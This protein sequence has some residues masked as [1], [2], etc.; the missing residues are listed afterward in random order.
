MRKIIILLGVL[1]LLIIAA[2]GIARY[3]YLPRAWPQTD[4]TLTLAGLQAPVEVFR[5]KW[6]I[7]NIYAQNE[8][9]LFFAQGYVHA[10][11]RLWQMDFN[12]RIGSGRLSELVGEATLDTDI[13]LRHLGMH[14]ASAKDWE[15]LSPEVR[16]ILTA[17]VDGVNTYIESHQGRLPLEYTI[18]G[19][20]PEPWKPLDSIVWAKVM[21]W[22]L[23][24]NWEAELLRARL[25]NQVGRQAVADLVPPYPQDAPV[26]VPPGV[27]N[28]AFLQDATLT[29]YRPIRQV[30]GISTGAWASNN[31]VVSGDKSTT[32]APLLANDP[33]LGL[34]IPSVWYANGLHAPDFDVVGVTFPGIPGIVIGHNRNI[35]WGVTNL[36]PDIQDL[37]IEKINPDNPNQYEFQGQ[38]EEMQVIQEVIRVKGRP[39]PEVV[40]V[41]ITRHG[42]IMNPAVESL[43]GALQPLAMR[44]TALDGTTMFE[45]L[46]RLNEAE[47]WDQFR[48][49][50]SHWA[51]AGQN[52][53][54]ADTAGNIGYQATG[55]VPIRK[56]GDGSVPVPGWTGDYEWTGF[57]P[58]D[59]MPRS[60]NPPSGYI[61]T[62]NNKVVAD[63][64]PYFLS[65]E[66]AAPYRAQRIEQLLTAKD[67][68]SP[69]DFRDI[70]ADT[71]VLPAERL[72]PFFQQVSAAGDVQAKAISALQ[73]WDMQEQADS[74]GAAVF[75]A[76]F[77]H[78]VL[79]TFSDELGEWMEDYSRAGMEA[80]LQLL[81]NPD[82]AWW[83][84]VTTPDKTETREEILSRALADAVQELQEK[85]GGNWSWGG[86]HTMTFVHQ[87][88]GQSGI[89]PLEWVF[90]KG[91]VRARGSQFTVNRGGFSFN[92]PYTMQA[93]SSYREILNLA[94]PSA[95]SGHRWDASLF[96]HTTG[97]SG[98]PF[99]SHYADMIAP[100]QAVEHQPMWF[101]REMIRANRVATLILVP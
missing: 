29:A 79:N 89:A 28:Y 10:G 43:K 59:E 31:W 19:V 98:Q 97:Q 52:F 66:W 50:L 99:H 69:E 44:W 85:E 64:Y 77:H 62:A 20:K 40:T 71:Y 63:S 57:I 8:H 75:E 58:F 23:G 92:E 22:D 72:M 68:L 100:W 86:L 7:P 47:N 70:Q 13:F 17:Y 46:R 96:Q 49:A 12:R 67:K 26:I 34:N 2:G 81:D 5:D 33:H 65:N 101:S 93:G 24:G 88:L 84:D 76:W 61:V 32:G 18:L 48:A 16:A 53:V 9:D 60:F 14:R 91:P 37:Y 78:A 42:P 30:L 11:D 74:A 39:D 95:S 54:Y 41:R 36:G 80:L 6:G 15:L 94:E 3:Y 90:N 35:G 73:D 82:A 21:A 38:W 87:P 4:G 1:L 25:I 56:S 45:A 55:L 27:G 51:I 83:D